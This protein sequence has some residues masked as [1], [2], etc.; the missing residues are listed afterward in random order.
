MNDLI[1]RSYLEKAIKTECNPYGKPTIDY[2]SGKKVLNII[3]NAPTVP[4]PDFK[5]GYKQAIIDGKT[6][7]SRPQGEWARHDEWMDCEYIG[8]FYHVNCPCEDGYFVKWPM[9]YCGNC[10]APMKLDEEEEE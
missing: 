3:D 2:E 7:F 10:G 5:E 9:K 6:N 8:G 1:S 4:L